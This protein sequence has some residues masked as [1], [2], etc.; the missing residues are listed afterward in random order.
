MSNRDKPIAKIEFCPS[1]GQSLRDPKSI[2]NEYWISS[3]TAYFCWCRHCSWSG[4]II[5]VKRI[6]APELA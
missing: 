5:Q 1:C 2:L 4:E 3:D 6:I